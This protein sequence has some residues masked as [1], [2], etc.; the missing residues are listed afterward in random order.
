[1]VILASTLGASGMWCLGLSSKEVE[2]TKTFGPTL[3]MD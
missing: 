2:D 3:C 1:M